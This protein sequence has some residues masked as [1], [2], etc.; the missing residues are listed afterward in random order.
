[1]GQSV[2]SNASTSVKT[3]RASEQRPVFFHIPFAIAR[4][5]ANEQQKL[6]MCWRWDRVSDMYRSAILIDTRTE[7]SKGFRH[8]SLGS[9][10]S[11]AFA[12][13]VQA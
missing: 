12:V 13:Q 4:V 1:M 5:S 9:R 11:A 7:G 10:C 6:A 2:A 8:S 3:V